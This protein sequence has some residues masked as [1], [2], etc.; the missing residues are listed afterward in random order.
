MLDRYAGMWYISIMAYEPPVYPTS[1][2]STSDLPDRVDDQDWL[3]AARYNE[4]KKEMRAIMITLG[5]LPQGEEE[6]VKARLEAI[7]AAIAGLSSPEATMIVTQPID[8]G[9]EYNAFG[10]IDDYEIAHV[11]KCLIP[12]TIK[13][14]HLTIEITD[15]AVTESTLKIGLYKDDGSEL[16]YSFETCNIDGPGIFTTTL[17]SEVEIPAGSYYLVIIQT[18]DGFQGQNGIWYSG[19]PDFYNDVSGEQIHTGV[20]F[21]CTGGTL[22]T[23]FDPVNDIFALEGD[24]GIIRFDH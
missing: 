19:A 18:T 5:T 8:P 2:P 20:I 6:T 4:L 13:A 21:G 12:F 22:P 1:I 17:P 7:E 14:N 23:S 3:Y 16:L 24:G 15:F 10:V 9:W 11:C